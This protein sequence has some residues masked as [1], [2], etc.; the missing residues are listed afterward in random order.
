MNP[1]NPTHEELKLISRIANRAYDLTYCLALTWYRR[2]ACFR[3][4]VAVHTFVCK[5]DLKRLL[6][7]PDFYF[8]RDVLG[9]RK[10]L[11]R[12]TPKLRNGF[13]PRYSKPDPPTAA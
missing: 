11:N 3:D 12:S 5:L 9:I 2:P 7:A 13:R 4:L 10:H 1:K 6:A 8:L